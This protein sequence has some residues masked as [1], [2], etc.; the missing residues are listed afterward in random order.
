MK[1]WFY[2]LSLRK[3]IIFSFFTLTIITLFLLT[4]ITSKL[5]EQKITPNNN[6]SEYT[7]LMDDT[8]TMV[9]HP[10]LAG[11]SV[12]D[13]PLFQKILS[14][15]S[16]N[17][18]FTA[19]GMI[20]SYNFD[21]TSKKF[22]GMVRPK[23]VTATDITASILGSNLIIGIFILLLTFVIAGYLSSYIDHYTCKINGVI[24]MIKDGDF[25]LKFDDVNKKLIR[26]D[27][28]IDTNDEFGKLLHGLDDILTVLQ[29][30]SQDLRKLTVGII[31]GE[32]KTR[33][34]DKSYK[35]DLQ[36]I[37]IGTNRIIDVSV[38]PINDATRILQEMSTGNL[39]VYMEGEYKGDHAIIRDAI[40][41]TIKSLNALLGEVKSVVNNVDSSSKKVADT[42]QELSAGAAQQAAA[43]EEISSS[44][45]EIGSQIDSNAANAGKAND[46]SNK[47]KDEAAAGNSQMSKMVSAMN[48]IDESSKSISKIIKVIDEIAFQTNLLALNAAVEAARAG[49]HGKGFAVVAEEVRNLAARSAEAA[50][51]TTSLIDN[52]NEKVKHGSTL[53]TSTAEALTR[54]VT[55]V[56]DVAEFVKE[57]S[58]ASSEQSQGV[59]QVGIGMKRIETVTQKNTQAAEETAKAADLLISESVQLLGILNKFKLDESAF[60]SKK[61][62]AVESDD[63]TLSISSS[64]PK[65]K[66]VA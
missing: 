22:V 5:V 18:Q 6:K 48:A 29:N 63:S 24:Q 35:G 1:Q 49:K 30:F 21:P 11:K 43:I 39:S 27:L 19:D 64:A 4:F 8:G 53:A 26:I 12:K 40:N 41:I 7:F 38:G 28:G 54:I 50:K 62:A 31:N 57:I 44:I 37:V 34:N 3:K 66:L 61:S 45:R 58:A 36:K 17:G 14:G 55:G 65:I 59:S 52:S 25:G 42:G 13:H 23:E 47:V 10:E 9:L 46:L 56:S 32:L 60:T 51:E 33:I 16:K 2:D 15:D 20:V